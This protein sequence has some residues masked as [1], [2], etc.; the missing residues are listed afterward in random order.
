MIRRM[1]QVRNTVNH[2][3]SLLRCLPD[4]QRTRNRCNYDLTQLEQK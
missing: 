4:K 2:V 1:V 3:V